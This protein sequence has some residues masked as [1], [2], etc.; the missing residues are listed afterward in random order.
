MQV[1]HLTL[2]E[3][4]WNSHFINCETEVIWAFVELK[5]ERWGAEL[6]SVWLQSI[7]SHS[8]SS[9]WNMMH[10]NEILMRGEHFNE[11]KQDRKMYIFNLNFVLY[12]HWK[13][14]FM[15]FLLQGI[16]LTQELNP[17]L[18]RLLHCRWI[19]YHCATWETPNINSGYFWRDVL[20]SQL[21]S[22]L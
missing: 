20:C 8:T 6:G 13:N 9:L 5:P 14:V 7:F 3:T 2:T 4:I 18:L 19:L 21:F 15:K 12:T 11:W 1:S 16:F 17:R 10:S 22:T